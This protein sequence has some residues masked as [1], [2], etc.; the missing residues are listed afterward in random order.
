MLEP[1][2]GTATARRAPRPQTEVSKGSNRSSAGHEDDVV[3]TPLAP[4]AVAPYLEGYGYAAQDAEIW[5]VAPCSDA[6]KSPQLDLGIT[7]HDEAEGH[8]WYTVVCAI[9]IPSLRRLEWKVRRRLSQLREYLYMHVKAELGDKVYDQNFADARFAHH[10]GLPGTTS[11]LHN[12][13]RALM[14]C[15]NGGQ[16]SPNVVAIVM[17]FLEAPVGEAERNVK[18]DDVSLE[19]DD[20]DVSESRDAF[21]GYPAKASVKRLPAPPS[22]LHRPNASSAAAA[23]APAA[24]TLSRS[25][26][27]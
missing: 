2:F 18:D 22:S 8:T 25:P 21:S 26:S 3:F 9:S 6:G 17:H 11:R 10:G 16:A 13:C 12:W 20:A 7:G 19:I 5:K 23:N 4:L 14:T 15:I 1:A 24:R 27:D